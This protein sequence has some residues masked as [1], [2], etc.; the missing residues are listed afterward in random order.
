MT[1]YKVLKILSLPS[2][3]LATFFTSFVMAGAQENSNIENISSQTTSTIQSTSSVIES[4]IPESA[5]PKPDTKAAG[6]LNEVRQGRVLN[7]AANLS[8]RMEAAIDRLLTITNRVSTRIDKLTVLGTDTNAAVIKL[9]EANELLSQ[10][11]INLSNIDQLV[12][13][14][15]T[16]PEPGVG[17]Q[18]VRTV[19]TETAKLIR[20]AHR[21]IFE[22]IA[23]LKESITKRDQNLSTTTSPVEPG[24]ET[25]E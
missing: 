21:T 9:N 25:T 8:N 3:V 4:E 7:L 5:Q 17:W 10:A 2:L 24:T 11:K 6:A 1:S 18:N 14:A 16:S 12:Y 13:N 15:T 20:Q 22:T 19:Y 23:L